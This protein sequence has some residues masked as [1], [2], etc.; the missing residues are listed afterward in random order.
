MGNKGSKATQSN[1]GPCGECDCKSEVPRVIAACN[2]A[3]KAAVTNTL[4]ETVSSLLGKENADFIMKEYTNAIGSKR[5]K[6][7]VEDYNKIK[8]TVNNYEGFIEGNEECVPCDCIEA[9]NEVIKSCQSSTQRIPGAIN[10]LVKNDIQAGTKK[11]TSSL[12]NETKGNKLINSDWKDIFYSDIKINNTLRE[13]NTNMN[14]GVYTF[15]RD[16]LASR[17]D[18]FKDTQTFK[19]DCQLNAFGSIINFITEEK[20][21]L[22]S[23]Y[24]YYLTFI[25]DYDSLYLHREAFSKTIHNKLDELKKIQG[26]I[27]KYKT[28]LHVDNRKNLYQSNNYDFYTN[29]RFYML[30]VYYSVIIIYLIFSKFFSEKQYT[31]KLLMLL[32]VIYLITPIILEHIINFVY[33]GYIYFLEYNNLKEDTKS[34]EDIININ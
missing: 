18:T 29:I 20:S 12:I 34:Y 14:S 31:N 30:L 17:H 28:T 25:K 10:N 8:E 1:N 19:A 21:I 33:E 13:G 15:T 11:L 16:A 24:N 26:K 7:W 27:D 5:N 22:D 4:E 2:N 3:G 9:A 6:K 32:L 23:L